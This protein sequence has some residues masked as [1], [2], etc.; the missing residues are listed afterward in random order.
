MVGTAQGRLCPPHAAV[1][2]TLFPRWRASMRI[3]IAVPW[4][5][6]P[7]RAVASSN[8]R[9]P[10]GRH[11]RRRPR[12]PRLLSPYANA[13]WNFWRALGLPAGGGGPPSRR[14]SLALTAWEIL[15]S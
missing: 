10:A 6:S 14:G 11:G 5:P 13:R 15:L 2:L 9:P 4:R 8:R 3:S 7:D 1:S 12:A